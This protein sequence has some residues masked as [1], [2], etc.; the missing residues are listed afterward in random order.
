MPDALTLT[1]FT[2]EE[3]LVLLGRELSHNLL[4][5]FPIDPLV[6]QE[7]AREWFWQ[8]SEQIKGRICGASLVQKMADATFSE[9]LTAVAALIEGLTTQTAASALAILI[10]RRGLKEY[11][12][13]EWDRL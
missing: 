4:A 5:A 6:A 7:K 9:A 13:Q 3:L 8:Q 1:G 10:L 11:C 2:D 12:R